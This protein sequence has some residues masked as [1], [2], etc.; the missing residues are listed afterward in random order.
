M[1]TRAEGEADFLLDEWP[2]VSFNWE[3]SLR[4]KLERPFDRLSS[5]GGGGGRR[6]GPSEA[7]VVLVKEDMEVFGGFVSSTVSTEGLE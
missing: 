1:I 2:F 5:T 3:F 4:F 6:D 7:D